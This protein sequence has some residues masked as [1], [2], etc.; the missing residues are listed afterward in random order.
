MESTWEGCGPDPWTSQSTD[1]GVLCGSE[2]VFEL[3]T[4]KNLKPWMGELFKS[5]YFSILQ[6][7]ILW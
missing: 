7:C 1:L 2:K 6:K 4:V 3:L 5:L